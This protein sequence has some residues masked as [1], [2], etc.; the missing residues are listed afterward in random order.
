M[1]LLPHIPFSD[2]TPHPTTAQ[3]KTKSASYLVPLDSWCHTSR[4]KP[5][6][7]WTYDLLISMLQVELLLSGFY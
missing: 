7:I 4:E 1:I 2:P 3:V 5:I 6:N